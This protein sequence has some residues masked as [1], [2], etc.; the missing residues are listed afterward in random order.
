[1]KYTPLLTEMRDL[2]L[3]DAQYAVRSKKFIGLLEKK[4]L[5]DIW[6][7]LTPKGKKTLKP[8]HE[9]LILQDAKIKNVDI[10]IIDP[11]SGPLLTVGIRSQMNSIAKNTLTY[12]QDIRGELAGL[13]QRY[14]LSVHGYIYLHPKEIIDAP[15]KTFKKENINHSKYARIAADISGRG[16]QAHII[17]ANS[18]LIRNAYD[19]F[20]YFVVDFEKDPVDYKDNWD[21]LELGVDLS[22]DNFVDNILQTCRRRF[23]FTDYF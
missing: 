12:F 18:H 11:N 19:H 23:F 9:I 21:E 6:D 3:E 10:A 15:G 2:Y 1:M 8:G 4:I 5:D 7:Q 16:E 22:L 13:I 20:S 17:V 14:P